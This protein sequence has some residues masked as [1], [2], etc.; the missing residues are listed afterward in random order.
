MEPVKFEY[1]NH[2]Y[3]DIPVNLMAGMM[4]SRWR[5][6][7]RERLAVLFHGHIWMAVNGIEHPPICLSGDQSFVIDREC[8]EDNR[9]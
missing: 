4:L 8:Y 2:H 1:V 5:L 9:Y 7:W 6:N 3:G